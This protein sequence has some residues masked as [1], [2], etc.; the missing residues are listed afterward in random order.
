MEELTPEQNYRFTIIEAIDFLMKTKEDLH[1]KLVNIAMAGEF[2][3]ANSVF[4][5]GDEIKLGVSEL[6]NCTDDN[7]RG[8]IR[9]YK[10]TE[11]TIEYLIERN[12]IKDDELG[13]NVE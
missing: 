11:E 4:E 13:I 5:E 10:I 9:L 6:K 3:D 2:S 12:D 1:I 8:I 7:I